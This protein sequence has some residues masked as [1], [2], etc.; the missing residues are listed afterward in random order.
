[1]S[2]SGAPSYRPGIFAALAASAASIALVP[3][4]G[5]RTVGEFLVT[6]LAAVLAWYAISGAPKWAVVLTVPAIVLWNPIFPLA[7][8]I[9]TGWLL[10]LVF[11]AVPLLLL[12]AG[13]LIRVPLPEDRAVPQRNRRR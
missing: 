11:V 6:I 12:V 10:V 5:W 8:Q 13:F 7:E 1:M 9:T 2:T 4:G 3:G